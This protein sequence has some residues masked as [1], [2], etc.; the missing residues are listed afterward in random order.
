[1]YAA[2]MYV[3]HQYELHFAQVIFLDSD[4]VAVADPTALLHSAAYLSTGAMLWPDYWQSWAAPDLK[5]IL[6]MPS[7]PPM[8]FESGQ[9]VFDK[10][11]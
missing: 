9:M 1:M 3:L 11:R 8:S 7:Q 2:S 6:D 5:A 10:E 4:N